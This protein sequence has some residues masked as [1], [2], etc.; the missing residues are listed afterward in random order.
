M[1]SI[2]N[3]IVV[4]T[5]IDIMLDI[6]TYDRQLT[7]DVRAM[8]NFSTLPELVNEVYRVLPAGAIRIDVKECV[9]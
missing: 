1:N 7:N 8:G 9:N 3:W 4:D 5:T 2:E 6:L